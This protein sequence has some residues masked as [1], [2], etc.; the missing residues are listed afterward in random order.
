MYEKYDLADHRVYLRFLQGLVPQQKLF[1]DIPPL[2][3]G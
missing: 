1:G 2:A 3:E